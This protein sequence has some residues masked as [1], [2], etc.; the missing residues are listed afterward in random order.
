MG[1]VKGYTQQVA[2]LVWSHGI[3][4]V[5]F[6]KAA[7]AP[8]V[9]PGLP[10]KIEFFLFPGVD[11]LLWI[12]RV[13][14]ALLQFDIGARVLAA[15]LLPSAGQPPLHAPVVVDEV[16]TGI[17][18]IQ[19]SKERIRL[20]TH[21]KRLGGHVR[22]DPEPPVVPGQDAAIVQTIIDHGCCESVVV[23]VNAGKTVLMKKMV[24]CCRGCLIESDDEN[25]GQSGGCLRVAGFQKVRPFLSQ[26][27]HGAAP[28]VRVK[29]YVI[30]RLL[31]FCRDGFSKRTGVIA[32][33]SCGTPIAGCIAHH[34]TAHEAHIM[35]SL[36][37]RPFSM[38]G[39]ISQDRERCQFLFCLKKTHGC[40]GRLGR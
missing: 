18:C 9:F 28:S 6:E 31:L 34:L 16:G 7:V 12:G 1:G 20:E 36:F 3:R 25:I 38:T 30:Y 4:D 35:Y 5:E 23:P 15:R 27:I 32:R 33:A 10:L 2:N 21:A 19:D 39:V 17:V 24:K 40:T 8:K 22:E 13:K 14:N 11:N 29:K 26:G 37:K